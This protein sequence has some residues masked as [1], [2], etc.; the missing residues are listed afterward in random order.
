M[1]QHVLHV[2][3]VRRRQVALPQVAGWR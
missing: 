3:A 2:Q 1:R